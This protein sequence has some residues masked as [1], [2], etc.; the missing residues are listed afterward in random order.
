[1]VSYGFPTEDYAYLSVKR[2]DIKCDAFV[3]FIRR[4]MFGDKD[5]MIVGF[6]KPF[7][8]SKKDAARIAKYV[9]Q[10]EA[11]QARFQQGS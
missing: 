4:D 7:L 2:P 9:Q 10:F 11:L 8:N 5:T 6:R 3:P 1:M